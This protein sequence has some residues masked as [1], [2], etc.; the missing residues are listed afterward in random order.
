MQ[1]EAER[2]LQTDFASCEASLLQVGNRD[3]NSGPSN[4]VICALNRV[5]HCL[6]AGRTPAE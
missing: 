5:H 2:H 4:M 3:L 1:R 6:P